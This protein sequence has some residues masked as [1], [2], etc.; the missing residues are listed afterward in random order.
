ATAQALLPEARVS[1]APRSQT[2]TRTRGGPTTRASCTLVRRGKRGWC[3]SAGPSRWRSAVAGSSTK[4]TQCGLPMPTA[5]TRRARPR[6]L[7]GLRHDLPRGTAAGDVVAAEAGAA[8]VDRD[9]DD[10]SILALD[11]AVDDAARGLDPEAIVGDP[12]VLDQPAREDAQAVAA[13]L[14]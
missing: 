12:A 13:L 2:R 8:H 7:D 3:S 9:V 1:P 4:T 14:G 10:A 5:V 11:A 6:T